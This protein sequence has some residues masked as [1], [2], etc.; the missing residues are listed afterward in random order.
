MQCVT[1]GLAVVSRIDQRF[2][3]A[4][5]NDVLQANLLTLMWDKIAFMW[6]LAFHKGTYKVWMAVDTMIYTRVGV[7]LVTAIGTEKSQVQR[8]AF[9]RGPSNRVE[10][11]KSFKARTVYPNP[12]A[13]SRH[14]A[15]RK[16]RGP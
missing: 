7:N 13:L 2:M 14:P 16:P 1:M 3:T 8:V 11:M 9:S 6:E 12:P 10:L 15:F 5:G 4:V